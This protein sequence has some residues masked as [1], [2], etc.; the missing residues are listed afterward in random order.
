MVQA[1]KIPVEITFRNL[2]PSPALE[3]LVRQKAAKLAQFGPRLMNCRVVVA[4]PNRR[5]HR[6]KIFAVMIELEVPGGSLWVNRTPP[7]DHRHE[8]ARVAIHDAF[9]AAKRRLQDAVRRTDRRL[10]QRA[11]RIRRRPARGAARVSEG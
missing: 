9:D 7:M 4:L 6:G 11:E 5:H 10:K 3:T 8:D 2:D 1:Q